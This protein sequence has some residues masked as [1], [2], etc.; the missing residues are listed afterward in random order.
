MAMPSAAQQ[1]NDVQIFCEMGT[2]DSYKETISNA[3]G[4]AS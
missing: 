1:Y 4:T 3:I 2:T